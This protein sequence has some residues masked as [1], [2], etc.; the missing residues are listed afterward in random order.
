MGIIVPIVYLAYQHYITFPAS[1]D[2]LI[3][4]KV[5]SRCLYESN[6][7]SDFFGRCLKLL[8]FVDFQY[9]I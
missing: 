3:S 2:F 9:L 1:G 4:T 8:C 5:F 6:F 7:S